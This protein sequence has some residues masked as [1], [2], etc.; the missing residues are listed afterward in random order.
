MDYLQLEEMAD[1]GQVDPQ[2]ETALRVSGT[3]FATGRAGSSQ[4][5]SRERYWL[6]NTPV[7]EKAEYNG[8]TLMLP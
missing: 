4:A 2:Y 3:S 1:N 5:N 6:G 7:M 8:E